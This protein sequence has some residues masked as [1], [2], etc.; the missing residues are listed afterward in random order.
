MYAID[1]KQYDAQL[2]EYMEHL[3][4]IFNK[5]DTDTMEKVKQ[6][7]VEVNKYGIEGIKINKKIYNSRTE[8]QIN[9]QLEIEDFLRK[10]EEMFKMGMM[11]GK[12]TYRLINMMQEIS[13]AIEEYEVS[14]QKT[15]ADMLI[16]RKENDM[17]F[18]GAIAKFKQL[19]SGLE[20]HDRRKIEMIGTEIMKYS[21]DQLITSE[22]MD[23]F[24]IDLPNLLH[25]KS[26]D[27]D[28]KESEKS[29]SKKK[30]NKK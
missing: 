24:A 27:G 13:D 5:L 6:S 23:K 2:I 4:R 1:N 7:M 25:M 18:Y 12:T 22:K 26:N 20:L 9:I 3:N 11:I 29:N 10:K 21:R 28:L 19:I 14:L 17:K 30:N 15:H 16:Q 8:K